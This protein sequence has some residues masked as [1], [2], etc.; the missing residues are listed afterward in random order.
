MKQIKLI[1]LS[2]IFGLLTLITACDDD[3]IN[4][5]SVE[6]PAT[7]TFERNG[8][9]SVSFGGQTTRIGMGEE[10]ISELK[11]V[12]N[13]TE[14]NLL[15][16]FRNETAAGGD[17]NPYTDADLNASTKSIKS[18]VAA[19]KDFFALNT[20][21]ATTIKADF[22]SW[23][24]SQVTEVVAN[25]NVL[26]SAGTAGQIADGSSTRYVSAKG[27]EYN[28]LVNK[29]LIGALMA[30]QMLNNYLGTAV[31]DEA[32]NQDNNDNDV[33]DGS[34]NYT[35]ME[36]KW[37][38]AYGYLYGASA[39]AANPN[40]TI[41]ADD[42]FLNK[43]VARVE[44][45]PDFAGIAD[46]IYNAFK[47]GRAAIVAKNYTVRDEQANIIREKISEIIGI[48]AVYYL[49][50]GK[51]GIGQT[52]PDYGGAFHDLSEGYGFIYSLRFT[53]NPNTGESYFTK[54]EVDQLLADLMGDGTNGL[55]DV[56]TTTLDALSTTIAAKFNFTVEQAASTN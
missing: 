9:T 24:S 1:Q 13:M 4:I 51:A 18:K 50:Q 5:P 42:N 30:D 19:S 52:T 49:Q 14:V 29:G 17:A 12:D 8:T 23:I 20:A 53:R 16:M 44:G 40:A 46:D 54:A 7:Y 39:D 28:Q 56:T 32:D 10:L 34:N 15:E 38:E 6:A 22:E 2:A 3:T 27:L 37:D 21:E 31:L 43:Y 55:W 41:G 25:K 26:A 33:L 45:D 35:T 11:D 36:H 48:R 47:L